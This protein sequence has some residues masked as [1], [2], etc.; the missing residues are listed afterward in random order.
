MKQTTILLWIGLSLAVV[1]LGW[2]WLA[3]H[4]ARLR[5][6][7]ATHVRRGQP[8]QIPADDGAVGITQFYARSGEVTAGDRNLI[9]YG[10]RNARSVRIEAPVETLMPSGEPLLLRRAA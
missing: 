7:D 10:V 1:R 8:Y 4:D 5:M 9:C 6:E 3:R 2:V